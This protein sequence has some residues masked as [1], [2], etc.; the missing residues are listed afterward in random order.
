MFCNRLVHTFAP[1][2]LGLTGAL[3]EMEPLGIQ[4]GVG[5]DRLTSFK[6]RWTKKECLLAVGNTGGYFEASANGTWCNMGLTDAATDALPSAGAQLPRKFISVHDICEMH[7][8]HFAVDCQH[9]HGVPS[10]SGREPR[11][12]IYPVTPVLAF[13]QTA[14][15][16]N[17][18]VFPGTLALAGG[19][20]MF[21]SWYLAAYKAIIEND[22]TYLE[23]LL[24]AILTTT[25]R[26]QVCDLQMAVVSAFAMSDSMKLQE[27]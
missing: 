10:V 5:Q 25:V 23:E 15:E 4:A 2:L 13:V 14:V 20:G 18:D 22:K 12:L 6:P 24:Q 26:V 3:W 27:K 7:D 1:R 17:Q 11:R 16:L 9:F 19:H 21:W 8:M